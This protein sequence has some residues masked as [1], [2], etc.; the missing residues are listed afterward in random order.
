MDCNYYS[1]YQSDVLNIFH[2]FY[3]KFFDFF[4]FFLKQGDGV[5]ILFRLSDPSA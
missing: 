1:T 3:M 2:L 5:G 4:L